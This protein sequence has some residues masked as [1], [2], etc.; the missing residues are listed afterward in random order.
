[1]KIQIVKPPFLVWIRTIE[2]LRKTI[3]IFAGPN[4]RP[5]NRLICQNIEEILDRGHLFST[6]SCAIGAASETQ[7]VKIEPFPSMG[8]ATLY[9]PYTPSKNNWMMGYT[10]VNSDCLVYHPKHFVMAIL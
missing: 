10:I 4:S 6:E 9:G 5:K 1:M 8:T 2:D 3:S 7:A